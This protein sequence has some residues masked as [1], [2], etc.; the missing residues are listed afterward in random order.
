VKL[1]KAENTLK[2]YQSSIEDIRKRVAELEADK[3]SFVK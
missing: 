1:R 3:K 2:A